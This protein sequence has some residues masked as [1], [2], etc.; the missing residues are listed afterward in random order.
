[1]DIA[2]RCHRCGKIIPRA[3]L[4]YDPHCCN[5]CASRRVEP[6]I[7]DLTKLGLWYYTQLD[8]IYERLRNVRTFSWKIWRW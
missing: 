5:K 7:Q 8:K 1:M 6:V 3:K 4:L 2:Y